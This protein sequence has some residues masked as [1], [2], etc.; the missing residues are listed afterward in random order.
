MRFAAVSSCMC[1]ICTYEVVRER[2]S[3]FLPLFSF[4]IV[5]LLALFGNDGF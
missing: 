3:R 4:E 5:A 2:L 1:R